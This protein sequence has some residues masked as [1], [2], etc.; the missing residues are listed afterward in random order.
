[1]RTMV[2]MMGCISIVLLLTTGTMLSATGRLSG[3]TQKKEK[4]KISGWIG[5]MVQDVNEKIARKVKLDSEEGAYVNEVLEDS[6]ADSAGIQESDVI[7]EFNGKKLFD[8]DDLAKTV[9]RT[10]PET[11]VSLVIVRG[12]EK[13]TL[14][15]TVGK[16]RESQHCM[17]G[18]MP[19]IP[20]VRVFVG[21]RI[22]GL[23]LLTLNEQLG[24]Y[25]GAPSN[26][27]VLVEEVEHKSTAE[28]AGFKA[29]DIVIRVGGKTVDAVEKIRK[30]L[31][32]YD[33]GDTVKFEVMRK[34]T[35][36][37]L[38]VEMEEQ[39]NIQKDFFFQKP[40]MRM[41]RTDPF[42]DAEMHLEMGEP[43]SEIDQVQQELER[44]TK[45]FKDREYDI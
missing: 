10:L 44:S 15:L 42:D 23:R 3:G 43:Q 16:K 1:M 4:T 33:E 7:I 22:L 38:N 25:F 11:K 35:K 2:R 41:F 12:G 20:D 27:G 28:K 34:N 31:Q 32:K 18:E 21:N 14:H 29:G 39:Q 37:I 40:H 36:K 45:N 24:E 26:E 30:E 9:H 5:V 17:F 6:P 19:N 8:S 13:K